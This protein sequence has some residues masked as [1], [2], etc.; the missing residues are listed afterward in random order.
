MEYLGVIAFVLVLGYSTLPNKIKN[1]EKEIKRIKKSIKGDTAMSKLISELKGQTCLV[2]C[3]EGLLDGKTVIECQVIDVD[4]EWVKI[5]YTNKKAENKVK[6][7]RIDT[8][9]SIEIS[10]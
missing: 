7:I 8:I 4:D 2:E 5:S 6:I 10:K 9:E 1:L 3:K